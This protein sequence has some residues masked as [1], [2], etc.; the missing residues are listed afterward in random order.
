MPKATPAARPTAAP[1]NPARSGPPPRG[2]KATRV[3]L[4]LFATLLLVGL[5]L[6]GVQG[7]LQRALS[8]PN[9]T[10]LAERVCSDFETQNY[11]DLADQ[12]DPAPTASATEPFS[13]AALRTQLIALD[14]IQGQV[15]RCDAGQIALSGSTGDQAQTLL[16]IQRQRLSASGTV[17]LVMR[18]GADGAWKVSRET[19]LT[20][21]L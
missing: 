1:A 21:G 17:L 11:T 5:A 14:R 15:T 19:G 16:T 10:T 8:A 7:I 9:P 13:A 6:Y 12:V 2:V 4:L 18:R 20:P 3:S